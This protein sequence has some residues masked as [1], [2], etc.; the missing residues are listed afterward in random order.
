MRI[1]QELLDSKAKIALMQNLLQRVEGQFSLSEL[2]RLSNMPKSTVSIV[3]DDWGKAGFIKVN[4]FGNLKAISLNKDFFLLSQ[5]QKLFSLQIKKFDEAIKLLKKSKAFNAGFITSAV[6]FGSTA[7]RNISGSS[8]LD[9]LI[10]TNKSLSRKRDSSLFEKLNNSI[11]E[12][13][14]KLSIQISPVYLTEQ[15]IKSRIDENDK[16]IKNVLLDGIIIK[17]DG[18]IESCRRIL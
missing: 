17:G 12:I 15:Q 2:A 18:F 8:D 14:E 4:Y 9:L 11:Q 10:A 3:I 16:F 1:M 5:L 13:S 6:V 7:R